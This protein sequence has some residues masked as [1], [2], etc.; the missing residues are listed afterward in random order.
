MKR[1]LALA[2]ILHKTNQPIAKALQGKIFRILRHKCIETLVLM[3]AILGVIRGAEGLGRTHLNFLPVKP[4]EDNLR[5][6]QHAVAYPIIP[7]F[8]FFSV[9]EQ[10]QSDMSHDR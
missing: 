4:E 8:S 6:N 5:P 9:C 1:S 3:I 10:V 2:K 7:S